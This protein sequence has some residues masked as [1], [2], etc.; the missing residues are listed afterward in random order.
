MLFQ[1]YTPED[2]KSLLRHDDT[3]LATTLTH[4]KLEAT[5]ADKIKRYD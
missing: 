2:L 5:L 1:L 3:R 4:N